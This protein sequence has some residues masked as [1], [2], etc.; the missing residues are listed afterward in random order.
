MAK[1]KIITNICVLI[2]S[3]IGWIFLVFIVFS[4]I[5][6][7]TIPIIDST[8]RLPIQ[9]VLMASIS[10]IA[11]RD[12][13]LD[14]D[15]NIVTDPWASLTRTDIKN[16]ISQLQ[17]G[18]IFFTDS[19]YVSSFFIP[20]KRQHS[21]IYIGTRPKLVEK[22]SETGDI[23]LALAPYFTNDIEE[24]IIDSTSK[25]V[26]IRNLMDVAN[27]KNEENSYLESIIA[28]RI[29]TNTGNLEIFLHHTLNNLGKNYDFDLI[30]EDTSTLYCS[31]LI[32]ESLKKIG[33]T[34][35]LKSSILGRLYV[36]PND[37]VEYILWQGIDNDD[38]S[39]LFA[40]W[41]K[42]GTVVSLP[43]EKK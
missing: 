4:L 8:I 35:T 29:L 32:Y 42:D 36:S 31:E 7:K 23:Y 37:A 5:F 41:K 13:T 20:G 12:F 34:L 11:I 3:T 2:L 14:D 22:F 38:F 9:S 18:D 1:M 25:G 27:I 40:L 6:P 15:Y 39:L 33:I 30:T 43:I 28:F 16:S 26:H 10:H 21:I 24:L 17:P 19:R